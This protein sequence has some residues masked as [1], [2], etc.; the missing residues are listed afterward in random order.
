M[1]KTLLLALVLVL[2]V[3]AWAQDSPGSRWG[4][5]VKNSNLPLIKETQFSPE[6]TRRQEALAKRCQ[7]ELRGRDR[8]QALDCLLNGL[9]GMETP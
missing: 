6:Q 3:L 8:K 4:Y 1:K 5:S 7:E 9:R 2:P